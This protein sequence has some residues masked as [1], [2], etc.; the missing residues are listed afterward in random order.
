MQ[1]VI[2]IGKTNDLNII[3]YINITINH[4]IVPFFMY[5]DIHIIKSMMI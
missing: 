2:W 5:S 3:Y 4:Y 1:I